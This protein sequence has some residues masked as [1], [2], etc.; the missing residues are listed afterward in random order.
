[1]RMHSNAEIARTM[2]SLHDSFSVSFE[3]RVF[4]LWELFWR[5]A[6]QKSDKESHTTSS[7]FCSF[8]SRIKK[9]FDEQS[10]GVENDIF[11]FESFLLLLVFT[12]KTLG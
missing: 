6:R 9:A 2:H 7:L 4:K 1:M 5:N 11:C 8:F 3:T 12:L 10:F